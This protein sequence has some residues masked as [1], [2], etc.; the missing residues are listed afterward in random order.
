MER[1]HS[2]GTARGH[3]LR[4][5]KMP[6]PLRTVSRPDNVALNPELRG[7]SWMDRDTGRRENKNLVNEVIGDIAST[8]SDLNR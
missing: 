8:L 3:E 7:K 4:P 6:G 2:F 5:W 1:Q